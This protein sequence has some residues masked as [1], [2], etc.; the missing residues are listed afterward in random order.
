VL[1]ATDSDGLIGTSTLVL[2]PATTLVTL[3]SDPPGLQLGLNQTATAAPH[4]MTV[5]RNSTTTVS[6][7]PD[8][9][10]GGTQYTFLGWSDSGAVTHVVHPTTPTL[11]LTATFTAVGSEQPLA[12]SGTPIAFITEPTGGGNKNLNVIKD[13]VKPAAGSTD[14][15]QQYDTYTGGAARPSDWVGYSYTTPKLFTRVV[16][17]EG[18]NFYDGGAFSSLTVQVR[19]GGVWT[20]V[21]GQAITPAYPGLNGVSYESFGISFTPV[22]GDGIRIFG[23][24]AGAAQFISIAELEVYGN[25]QAGTPVNAP[26]TASA[27][28]DK[29]AD[30]GA[31]VTLNGS[32]S[33]PE[34]SAITYLWTQTAGTAVTLTGASSATLSFTA[35]ATA[36]TLTFQLVTNDGTLSSVPDTVDVVVS[37]PSTTNL[38]SSGTPVALITNPTGGGN[39]NLNVIKDGVK[40]AVGSND[41]NQ[42]Y[43][44][45]NG[46]GP[47]P[48]DWIGY[49]FTSPKLF[50]RV[51][52]Q[53]GK[54]F[55][56]GGSFATLTVQVR[57]GGVW[58]NVQALVSNPPYAGSNGV[59]YGTFSLTF[60]PVSGDGIRVFGTPFGSAHFVSIA[61]LEVYGSDQSGPPVNLPPTA[62]AG[63]DRNVNIGSAV[64][65]T[66][67]GADPEGAAITYAW[68]Q[69][70]GTA[71]TLTGANTAT[72]SFT[73]PAAPTTLTFQLTTNDGALGSA[74]DSVNV[75]VVQPPPTNTA[76]SANA[77]ADKTADVGTAVSLSGSGSDPEG[78]AISYLWTQI[79]GTAV[80]L[81]GATTA[82]PSFT[83]PAAPT[84]LTFQL[85]TSDGALSSTPDTV[86]VTV[87][88]P[89]PVNLAPTANAGADK[90]ANLGSAVS[91]NGSGTDP[92]GAAITYSWTQIGGPVVTL[93][94][95]ATATASFTAPA[96]PTTLTF[97]LV[98]NDGAL[99]STPDVVIVTVVDPNTVNLAASGT[100]IAFIT[101]PTGGG[102]KSLNVIKDGVKPAVGSSDNNQQ[103]DTYAG[104]GARPND[105]IGYSF[106]SSKLF[107]RVVF[108]EGRNFY[109]GGAFSSVTVQ[110][111]SSG[112]WTNVTGFSSSP[113]YSGLNGVSYETFTLTFNPVSGDGIRISGAPAGAAQF[114]S[115]A[116]LEVYGSDQGGPPPNMPPSASAGADQN[117]SIGANVTLNGSGSDPEGAAISYQWS[118]IGG[119]A[120]T[121]NGGTTATPSFTAPGVE[122]TLTFQLITSDGVQSSAADTVDVIVTN[123]ATAN[124]ASQGT[125]IAFIT[126]PTGG[127]NK[128]LSVIKDG[129]KPA[130]GS[131]NSAQQYDTYNGGGPRT[132]D[133]IGYTFTS[134]KQ[135]NRVV[136]QEGRNFY[137]GGAFAN[138]TVQVRIGGVWT[139]V[140]G[141]S[142]TPTYSGLNGVSFESFSMTFT[143]VSGDGIRVYGAPGG[144]A[145]FVSIAEL[146][147]YGE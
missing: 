68:V 54:N 65:V 50:N 21:S 77:G 146:E 67:S 132:S 87:V 86:V 14:N 43:D 114:V 20:N 69:T 4:S 16:F 12:A 113:T 141:L 81:T 94:G 97:Q 90:N 130:V 91:L 103:N 10:L 53:E 25:H 105:W 29:T 73:A 3:T 126:A 82:T 41:Y 85:T 38:A 147:V 76:P 89:P 117:V 108:Q 39:K 63:A 98:T 56:D 74:P 26:P 52:F 40:P 118:Q 134:T 19:S 101:N 24:P 95:A 48:E 128:D 110:V 72:L 42:Q 122:T 55:Y 88:Q 123:P 70:A 145:K 99:S 75:V 80:T 93:S 11:G 49:T 7:P 34:G 59:N 27:G 28:P 9:V 112:V 47:R 46:G 5:I 33:D 32:G 17:Q 120:V 58:S 84:T 131:S 18:R 143:P 135:F 30:L 125:P 8:Q 121:L 107:T 139:D 57:S 115:V 2:N 109:D 106:S 92:E 124:L 144:A 78:T 31:A 133:W 64:S 100:P 35:P 51:V 104:G 60:T 6:A 45:Y 137:D 1:I 102:N 62:N 79:G 13:G 129:V 61:E 22:S 66:G 96:A 116:E 44:T 136:F 23:A 127:G 140:T 111:R 37:D 36:Q 138:L 15:N 119:A 142:S 71:V 83:A